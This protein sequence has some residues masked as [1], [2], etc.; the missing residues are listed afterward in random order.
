MI[1]GRGVAVFDQSRIHSLGDRV[2][3]GAITAASTRVDNPHGLL[4]I[5]SRF[6][7][8]AAVSDVYL[9]HTWFEGDEEAAVGKAIVRNSILGAHI[10][11]ADPWAP[12]TR[13][14][15]KTPAPVSQVLY[16]SDDYYAPTTGLI[17]PEV[18]LAE[19]GNS[20]PGAAP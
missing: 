8:D 18:F 9:G 13:A 14:T 3:G 19:F 10:R 4:I 15:P 20:G 7:A 2:S 12:T 5:N 16:T 11:V 1:L 6:T 17:P